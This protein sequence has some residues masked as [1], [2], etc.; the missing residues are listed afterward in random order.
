LVGEE[1]VVTAA[2]AAGSIRDTVRIYIIGRRITPAA[3]RRPQWSGWCVASNEELHAAPLGEAA[4]HSCGTLCPMSEK[5]AE[6]WRPWG[7][8]RSSCGAIETL[9][10]PEPPSAK[11]PSKQDAVIA[12]LDGENF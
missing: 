8:D 12:M 9:P 2:P 1:S 5:L 4:A 7:T 3:K 6:G 10:E 11:R